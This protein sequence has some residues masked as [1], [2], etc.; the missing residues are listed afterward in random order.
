MKL[1]ATSTIH[2]GIRDERGQP[3][4][5]VLSPGD[6]F[7]AEAELAASL[8]RKRRAVDATD[9]VAAVLARRRL[10]TQDATAPTAPA[11][12]NLGLGFS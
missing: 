8:L 4:V 12:I 10:A 11:R 7:E 6:E 3:T 1:I 2:H 9:E 5:V